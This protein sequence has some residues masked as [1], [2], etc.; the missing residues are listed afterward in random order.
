MK[1]EAIVHKKLSQISLIVKPENIEDDVLIKD[2]MND[3]LREANVY[4]YYD[5]EKKEVTF[6]DVTFHKMNI[7]K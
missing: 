4:F 3:Y 5:S 7:K 6:F 1:V 2:I